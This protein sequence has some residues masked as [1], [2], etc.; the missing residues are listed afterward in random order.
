MNFLEFLQEEINVGVDPSVDPATAMASVK[1]DL[2]MANNNP[3]RYNRQQMKDAQDERNDAQRNAQDD[4]N[5]QLKMQIAK[6]KE[7]L[8]RL[9][10]QLASQMKQAGGQ[11]QGQM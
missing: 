7:R 3:Q 6:T 8:A 9:N 4:P 10:A 5:A 1:R 2:R 11:Q